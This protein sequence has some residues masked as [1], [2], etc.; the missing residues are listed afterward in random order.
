MVLNEIQTKEKNL[1]LAWNQLAIEMNI[2]S[3]ND[4]IETFKHS[5]DLLEMIAIIGKIN[6]VAKNLNSDS[7]IDTGIYFKAV[8][9]VFN[10]TPFDESNLFEYYKQQKAYYSFVDKAMGLIDLDM[11]QIPYEIEFVLLG[12]NMRDYLALSPKDKEA[13]N[14]S[15]GQI[16]VEMQIGRIEIQDF[17]TEAKNIVS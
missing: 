3:S 15:Y 2:L 11:V 5:I 16:Y 1:N 17:I 7:S 10:E 8:E 6:T 9:S 4:E 14:E 12:K 13:L